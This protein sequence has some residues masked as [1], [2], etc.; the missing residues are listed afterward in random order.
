MS[1]DYFQHP[2]PD[3]WQKDPQKAEWV[4]ALLLVLD[5]LLRPEGAI[6]TSELTTEVVLTQQEKLNLITVTQ[7]VN[8][9]TIESDTNT[10]KA[11]VDLIATSSPTY[12]ISND[13]TN[14]NLNADA[15]DGAISATYVQAEI[16][17]L[18]DAILSQADV[19]STLAR[20]LAA[21]NVFDA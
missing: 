15:A 16:E 3:E 2:T 1:V 19:I 21:K 18:R 7:D 20:D 17:A 13:G 6:E 8:L 14:R 11:A 10:N 12:T 4:R 9:D 5:D